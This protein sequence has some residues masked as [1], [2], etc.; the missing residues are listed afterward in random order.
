MALPFIF[1]NIIFI[2][3]YAL[4]MKPEFTI[5]AFYDTYKLHFGHLTLYSCFGKGF[6]SESIYNIRKK[7]ITLK[8]KFKK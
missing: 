5:I 1:W 8:H 3:A 6:L 7:L 2:Y 4:E